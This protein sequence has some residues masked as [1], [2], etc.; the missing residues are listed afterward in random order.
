MTVIT[1]LLGAVIGL[2]LGALGGGGSILT[3]PALVYVIGQP[4]GVAT[5]SSLIIVGATALIGMVPH[6]LDGRVR[7]G[8]GVTFAALGVL[9]ALVGSR[10]SHL[11]EPQVLMAGFGLLLLVVAVTMWRKSDH[12]PPPES[13]S[14]PPVLSLSPLRCE[15]G[16]LARLLGTATAVGLLTGFFG[17][18][19]GFAI[20]P[21]LVVALGMPLSEAVGTSL[22]VIAINSG[23]ALAVRL[24]GPHPEPD[25]R[26]IGAFLGAAAIAAIAGSAVA[27]RVNARALARAFAGML[28]AVAAYTLAHSAG[29]LG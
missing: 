16:R 13:G 26:V 23:I 11:V 2:T 20:V 1:A 7:F 12:P 4:V 18:G 25:W 14:L 10:Y 29:L 28:L 8:R 17:V 27:K 3:V 19:G 22:L 24:S 6:A 21:A 9:G 5:I 15:W